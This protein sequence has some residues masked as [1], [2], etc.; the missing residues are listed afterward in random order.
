MFLSV[1]CFF[2]DVCLFKMRNK[3]RLKMVYINENCLDVLQGLTKIPY[4]N[5]LCS[6]DIFCCCQNSSGIFN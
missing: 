5:V 4:Y 6:I 1:C 2:F 3:Y